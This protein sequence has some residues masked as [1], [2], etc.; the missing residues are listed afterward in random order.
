MKETLAKLTTNILN[1]FL[2]CFVVIVLLAFTGSDNAI[3][4]VKWASIATALSVLPVLVVVLFLVRRKKLD[5]VFGNT[6]RQRIGLYLLATA[7]GAMG[8]GLMLY[9]NAPFQLWETFAAGLAAILIFMGVNLFWKIS[10]H[11]AFI[12]G[13]VTILIIVYGAAVAWVVILLP[14]VAWARV[15]LKQHSWL[16]AV[17]GAIIAAV[18]VGMVFWGYGIG[19]AGVTIE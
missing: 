7:L 11:T 4:A 1:P 17:A 5:G 2:I 9:L 6:R 19:G 15:A 14:P 13:A 10:L 3:E 18:V 16:Q 8:F 12:A